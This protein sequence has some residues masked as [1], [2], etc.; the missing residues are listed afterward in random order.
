MKNKN[1]LKFSIILKTALL[2]E[3][4]NNCEEKICRKHV[5][6]TTVLNESKIC[7]KSKQNYLGGLIR[8]PK[9]K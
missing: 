8:C 1:N 3:T 6:Y 2:S 7:L 4:I 5:L 9:I